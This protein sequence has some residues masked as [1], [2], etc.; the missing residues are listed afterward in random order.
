MLQNALSNSNENLAYF[1]NLRVLSYVLLIFC[2]MKL[3][4][5][6]TEQVFLLP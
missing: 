6:G 5:N 2:I 3:L 1:E 4:P